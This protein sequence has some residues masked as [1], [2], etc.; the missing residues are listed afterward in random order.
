MPEILTQI[1][2]HRSMSVGHIA[3]LKIILRT[4]TIKSLHVKIYVSSQRQELL[5]PYVTS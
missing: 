2:K 1:R 5:K 4:A 3:L